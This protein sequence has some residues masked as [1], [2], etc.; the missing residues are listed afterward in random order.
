[1]TAAAPI[2]ERAPAAATAPR[3]ISLD[4]YRGLVI[5]VMTFVNYLAGVGGIPA[6]AKHAPENQEGYTLVDVVFPA[7]LFIV[8]V[9]L[10]LAFH[11]RLSEGH[12]RTR[13]LG[14]VLARSASL[15]FV[16]VLLVNSPL[17]AREASLLPKPL[18]FLLALGS[19]V[20][21]WS[22]FPPRL[23][24]AGRLTLVIKAGAGLALVI[25]L[26]LF[27]GR[28]SAGEI[29]WLQHSWWG[30]PGLIGWAYLVCSLVYL[31]SRG[32]PAALMGWLGLLLALYIGNRHGALD[33]LGPV[34]GFIGIGSVLGS[35]AAS[36]LMGVIVGNCFLPE[37]ALGGAARARFFLL[38]GLGL[39]AAGALLR[40]LHGIN[41]VAAT[42]S[43]ALVCGGLCCLAFLAVHLLLEWRP[44]AAWARPLVPVG[45]NA[46]LAYLLPGLL[47]NLLAVFGVRG[48]LWWFHHGWP[49]VANTALLTALIFALTWGASRLGWWLKL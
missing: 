44:A 48:A 36:A 42:E 20:L 2:L 14:R 45:R 10:P 46:L 32:N 38:Y 34:H 27:R 33:W 17:Y 24:R 35:T 13:L 25:L 6:W 47:G 40:P 28:N 16:G 3:L 41:K 39:Y 31:G 49:G 29:V 4:V 18:W 15:I 37:H 9:A 11:R 30:I 23:R 43:Y 7:F 22:D 26:V 5:L 21:L 12:R 1:M 8:G 19:V